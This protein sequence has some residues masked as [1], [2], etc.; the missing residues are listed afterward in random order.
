VEARLPPFE[1]KYLQVELH[2]KLAIETL[3]VKTFLIK[4]ASVKKA[5]QR[6]QFDRWLETAWLQ[7]IPNLDLAVEG[8]VHR[9]Q[10]LTRRFKRSHNE[11]IAEHGLTWEEWDVLGALRRAGPPF[12][13]SAGELAKLAELSSGAMTNRLD[14]MEKAGFVKRL[15]DPS[16]RRGVL[17]ELTNLGRQK[18][19]D[20]TGAEAERE[21]LIGAALTKSEKEQLNGLLRR[22]MLEFERRE[23]E[24][25]KKP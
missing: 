14:R 23:G 19:L 18:W 4:N 22:L 15:P 20:S 2:R 24:P 13:R 12:R 21:A 3:D 11:V 1:V 10:T 5:D 8:I 17:I 16:D 25:P 9:M 6:D 7:D